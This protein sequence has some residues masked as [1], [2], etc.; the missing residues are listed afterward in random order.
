GLEAEGRT[1]ARLDARGPAVLTR[2]READLDRI[3]LLIHEAHHRCGGF[4]VHR[5]AEEGIAAM[6]RAASPPAAPAPQGS[7]PAYVLDQE[8]LVQALT[9][10]LVE[11]NILATVETLSTAFPNRYYNYPSGV[12]SAGWI[13][14]LWQGYATAAGRADV[15][16][17]LWEHADWAQP[18]VIA[19]IPGTSRA[20]QIVV[21]GGH[22]DSITGSISHPGSPAPGADDNAS[23]I[24]VLSEVLRAALV[25]DFQPQRTVKFMAYAAEEVGLRGSREIALAHR[26]S[27]AD[28]V[29][30][31]QFDMTAFHGSSQDIV[32]ITD[33]TDP[34]LNGFVG[35]LIDF[36]LPDLLRS[37]STC[38][39]ACS[40][41]AAWH[42]QGYP[43]TMPFEAWVGQHNPVIHTTQDNL[44]TLGNSATHAY[45][46]ARLGAAFLAELGVDVLPDIF[47][48]G[49][50][51]GT[52]IAW[53]TTE[54]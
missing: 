29:A 17:E 16:V 48:D 49:F 37:V 35:N 9:A 33:N 8:S 50:E 21:M 14:D 46:F 45:K 26:N 11:A 32:L 27:E 47:L 28:V 43:A 39:Y 41:H 18:S 2:V 3:S 13:R 10:E 4:M 7:A 24:A 40:D 44:A 54:P 34:T 6:E 51:S 19:T 38:G 53:S 36:Y 15:T 1:L 30:A 22:Q 23:G 42:E 20:E 25:L 5:S 31:L 52:P 12:A